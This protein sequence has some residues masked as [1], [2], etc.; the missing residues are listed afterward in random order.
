MM[1]PIEVMTIGHS[2]HSS[3]K[4]VALLREHRVD[5]VADVRSAPYSR[6][7]HQ[8]DREELSAAL[9]KEGIAYSFLGE[10]LGGRPKDDACYEH[11]RVQYRR[12]AITDSFKRGIQ[13]VLIGAQRYRIALMCAEREPLECHRGLLI[14]PELEKV[15]ASI[16]HIHSDGT[17]ETH[18]QAVQRLLAR[19]GLLKQSLFL[20]RSD[21]IEEAY[22]KQQERVAHARSSA[23]QR[24]AQIV[25]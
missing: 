1:T 8:F 14:A 18:A 4:F 25:G 23:P 13:R 12:V 22:A 16:V 24:R 11:G 5:A 9:Q 6:M 17:L 7:H 19:F 15:G 21:L 3:E 2:N 10:E 20:S